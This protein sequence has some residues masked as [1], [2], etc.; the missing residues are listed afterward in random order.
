MLQRKLPRIDHWPQALKSAAVR[1]GTLIEVGPGYRP[2]SWPDTPAT[3]CASIGSLLTERFAAAVYT[4]AWV[5][6][7][8]ESPG[9]PLTF[10]TR[11]GRVPPLAGTQG[12]SLREFTL[13]DEDLF[14]IGKFAVTTPP[15][16]VFDIVRSQ[17]SLSAASTQICCRLLQ[18]DAGGRE[19][20]EL[21]ASRSSKADRARVDSWLREIMGHSPSCCPINRR[22]LNL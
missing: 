10:I 17:P 4:A 20:V 14:Y 21:L 7:A 1:Q 16:T 6:G 2:A 12:V 5:W 15:R 22:H 3:R 9:T 13:R 19:V 11:G 8:C 18:R